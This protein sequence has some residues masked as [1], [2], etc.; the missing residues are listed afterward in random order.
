MSTITQIQ[1]PVVNQLTNKK[2]AT[3]DNSQ[4]TEH[5]NS[6]QTV[7]PV[8]NKMSQ[9]LSEK[10]KPANSDGITEQNVQNFVPDMNASMIGAQSANITAEFVA[11]LLNKNPYEN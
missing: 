2:S 4:K 8:I 6:K 10:T 9:Q 7:E 5:S 11:N 1:N 3:A